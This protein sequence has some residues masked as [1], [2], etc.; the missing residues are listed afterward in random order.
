MKNILKRI[1]RLSRL[2]VSGPSAWAHLGIYGLILGLQFFAVWISV[3]QIR[4][5]KDFFDALEQL[6]SS[7]AL[8]QV[9]VFAIL[10]AM[11][12][13]V[14]LVSKWLRKN[15]SMKLRDRLT[16]RALDAWMKNAAYWHLR[17][18]LSPDAFDN[19]DQRIAQDCQLFVDRLLLETLDLISRSVALV[20]YLAVLWSISSFALNFSLLGIDFVIPRYM[21]WGAFIYVAIS[22]LITHLAGYKLKALDYAQEKHEANFRHALVQVRET[23]NEIAQAGGE[24]AERHRLDS[25]FDAIKENWRKLIRREFLLGLFTR[26]YFQTILRIPM[27]LAL[28]AYFAGAVT[29]GGLMQLASA[30]SRVVTTISW[31]IF[32]YNDLAKFVAVSERLD[33]LFKATKDPAP[34][35]DTPQEIQRKTS[36]DGSL[37]LKDLQLFTPQGRALP[38][39]PDLHMPAGSTLWISGASGQG[40]T[41]LLAA[42]SGLWKYG[43]GQISLPNSN[44]LFLPQTPHVFDSSI[45]AA[46]CY[47]ANPA[48]FELEQI[49]QTLSKLGLQRRIKDMMQNDP[50][51]LAG[52]SM[53]ERQR[54]AMARILLLRP[55]WVV[56]DEATSALDAAAENRL[57]ALIR[58]AL[59]NTGILC[60]SH[61]PPTALAPYSTLTIGIKNAEIR[62]TP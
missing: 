47:P 29:L 14:H 62:R 42:I 31:F 20:S 23:S 53:G 13:S 56:L 57:F 43:R 22:S 18:G 11:S 32:S 7:G 5:S 46:A 58:D 9:G 61:R 41:T 38:P 1:I 6:D 25:R 36:P 28:P 10:V 45:A 40:K 35:P 37:N 19:P 8:T 17:P 30:F 50:K 48:D 12:A 24:T 21:V 3:R 15:L 33:E 55:D 34:M 59:P 60:V 26:P 4:W 51:H 27:F 52:L 39:V 49:K 44:M 54:L 16:G 2:S